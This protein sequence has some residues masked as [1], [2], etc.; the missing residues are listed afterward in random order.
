[1]ALWLWPGPLQNPSPETGPPQFCK[2]VPTSVAASRPG[3]G[4]N[5]APR[6]CC[7][8][9]PPR[10]CKAE[11][12]RR[13]R[14]SGPLGAVLLGRGGASRQGGQQ[15]LVQRLQRLPRR[16]GQALGASREVHLN[17][18]V[19]LDIDQAQEVV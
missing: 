16:C 12:A 14:L 19:D 10:F 7:R 3:N 2:V 15:A 9:G 4:G 13:E 8:D 6:R 17:A 1:M 5:R 18:L 11:A